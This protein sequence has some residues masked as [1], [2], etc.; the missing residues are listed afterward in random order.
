MLHLHQSGIED[1][2][3]PQYHKAVGQILNLTVLVLNKMQHTVSWMT[4]ACAVTIVPCM[5]SKVQ[6]TYS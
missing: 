6:V 1:F 3:T 5:A 2:T 4:C